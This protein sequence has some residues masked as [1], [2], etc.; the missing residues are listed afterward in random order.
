MD[1]NK[2]DI[3]VLFDSFDE[4]NDGTISYEEFLHVMRGPLNA[5]RIKL[6]DQAFRK[7]D[8]TGDG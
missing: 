2:E 4:N 7:L 5:F 1:F 3:R 8:R 6:I